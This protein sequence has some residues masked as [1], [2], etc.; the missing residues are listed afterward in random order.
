[1]ISVYINTNTPLLQTAVSLYS[2]GRRPGVL[3]QNSQQLVCSWDQQEH[4]CR[5]VQ[6][7]YKYFLMLC[8]FLHPLAYQLFT[9]TLPCAPR[10]Y[11]IPTTLQNNNPV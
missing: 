2:S 8:N 3:L 7:V 6:Y 11:H 5:E 9:P 4:L 1:M 10:T